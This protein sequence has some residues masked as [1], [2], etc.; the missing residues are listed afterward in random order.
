M[1]DR[2]VSH[3]RSDVT[4]NEVALRHV[5]DGDVEEFFE[6]QAEPGAAEM[7]AVPR[8]EKEAHV[9]HW[10][11]IRRDDTNVL[12]TILLDGAVAG[13][14][15]SW[16][17]EDKRLVGYWI[18]RRYWGRGIATK[19][20]REFLA[21]VNERPLHAHVAAHNAGSIRVLEK[22]GFV[23]IRRELLDDPPGVEDLLMELHA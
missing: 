13:N 14:V 5:T 17:D 21:V 15:V 6:H 1:S 10:E 7:A 11:R 8:R 12:R 22:C 20:L 19:A 23:T 18:A 4:A 2:A 16:L 9:E 3:A